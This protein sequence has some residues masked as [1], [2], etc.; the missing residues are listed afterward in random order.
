MPSARPPL[1]AAALLLA[2]AHVPGCGA[3]SSLFEPPAPVEST[4]G[5]GIVDPG[6]ECDDGNAA[7]DDACLATCRFARCGD[8]FTWKG[9]E[10]C[11]DGN[12]VDTDGCRN[13]CALPTCGDGVV[14]PGEEC[15]DGNADDTDDCT[16]RC[17]FAH[18]GDGFVHAGVEQCD[19]AP[20]N[21]DH[22]AILLRQGTLFRVVRPLD[23]TGDVVA[24]YAYSSASA[25]TGLEALRA[26]ELYLHRDLATGVLSLV[27]EHGIDQGTSGLAQ[28]QSS[29]KEQFLGL[30]EGVVIA[31]ADDNPGELFM[32]STTSAV[33]DWGFVG[34]TDGGAFAGL[35]FPGSW[36]IDVVPSFV[37]G[38]DTFRFVD[39][40][41]A[42]IPLDLV[43]TVTLIAF[44]DPSACRLDCTIPRC[45][46]GILDGGEVC[47]DGNQVGGDGCAADC[48]S[49]Q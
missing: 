31:V 23:R 3:R 9:A 39:G 26:S 37:K 12:T 42:A 7:N 13:R 45:G 28:P 19:A 8:G 11:D 18:C 10:G 35:P 48:K 44:A 38:I 24:F 41:G 47:D 1:T 30:P 4:C 16:S 40:D 32:D 34:N 43:T 5:D 15:D 17:L 20:A 33:G 2:A 6:E 21:A 22:P 14:D 36:K 27:T 29:V 25:H 46:D 49:L